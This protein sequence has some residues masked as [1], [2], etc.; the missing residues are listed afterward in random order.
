MQPL[1]EPEGRFRPCLGAGEQ[2]PIGNNGSATNRI[3]V[4]SSYTATIACIH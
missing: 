4:N 1:D 3:K 2:P